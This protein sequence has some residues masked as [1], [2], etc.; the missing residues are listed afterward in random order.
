MKETGNSLRVTPARTPSRGRFVKTWAYVNRGDIPCVTAA[1]LM[2]F[3]N[4]RLCMETSE[5]DALI[6]KNRITIEPSGSAI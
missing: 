1:T 6:L 5:V 2:S 3:V 4:S